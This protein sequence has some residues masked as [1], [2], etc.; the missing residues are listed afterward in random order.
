[1]KLNFK[2]TSTLFLLLSMGI[3]FI[4]SGC[5]PKATPEPTLD[6]NMIFTQAA[7]TVQA[8]LTRT[9]LAMPT[10]TSTPTE[11]P[12]QTP[13]PTQAPE[14]SPTTAGVEATT[15]SGTGATST[16]SANPNKMQFVADV[17]IPDNTVID[18]GAKFV[19]TWR[20]KNIGSTVWTEDYKIRFWA[21]NKMGAVSENINLGKVVNPNQEVEIS[22]EFTAP[23]AS[24]EY[25]SKWVLSDEDM[26]NFGQEFYVLIKVGG[27][28]TP[29]ATTQATQAPT[30]TA[31]PTV[32]ITT[33]V[34]TAEPTATP[35][36]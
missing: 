6:A 11:E 5:G 15:A 29:T 9:A 26:A 31:T 33:E 19:K 8:Q 35:T 14:A 24:G 7:E 25:V 28:S 1:M 23:L 27:T 12:T 13:E 36:P 32:E 30:A 2:T 22:I 17:T 4:I 10:A 18:A 34:P 3:I 20:I 21:G 16:V